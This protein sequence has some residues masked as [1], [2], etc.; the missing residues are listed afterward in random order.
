M[1]EN[2]CAGRPQVRG[3]LGSLVY[4]GGDLLNISGVI[5]A[6]GISS[7]MGATNKLLLEYRGHT[8]I[9]EVLEGLLDSEIDDLCI[10]TGFD[11]SRVEAQLSKYQSDRV[12]LVYNNNHQLG[13]AESIKCAIRSIGDSADAAL[14]MVADKPG[15][16][17]TLINRA[18]RRFRQGRP[19]VL[20]VKTPAGRG[21]PIIFSRSVF[22]DLLSSDGDYFGNELLEKYKDE[23]IALTDANEQV[24][25]NTEDDYRTFLKKQPGRQAVLRSKDG[26]C[27]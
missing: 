1:R 20:Y 13:R 23:V 24:N 16:S 10:V 3:T 19:A 9:E 14:F 11:R 27:S 21:H 2:T 8:I 26:D 15:V 6:A 4:V 12:S 25:I 5:L 22:G 17:T 18:I 7:R